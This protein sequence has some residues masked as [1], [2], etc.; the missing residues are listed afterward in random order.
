MSA[1]H[2]NKLESW[3]YGLPSLC[4]EVL[5][6]PFEW[7]NDNLKQVA[8]DPD[9]IMAAIPQYQQVAASVGA[10]GTALGA[11]RQTLSASWAGEAYEAFSARVDDIDQQIAG[12]VA[13]L[14]QMPELLKVSAD[15]CIEGANLIVDIVTSLIMFALST[16]AVNVALAIVTVGTS[17]A[18]GVAAVV[19]RAAT[20]TAKVLRVVEKVAAVLEKVAAAFTKIEEALR[21]ILVFLKKV[22]DMLVQMKAA[23]KGLKGKEFLAAQAKFQAANFGVSTAI[24]VGTG[25]TVAPPG[26]VGLLKDAGQDYV[27]GLTDGNRAN[28]L[29]D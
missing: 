19:A 26:G 9:K 28:Q 10:V 14:G 7:M 27:E 4:Q 29:A 6:E 25:G 16:I 1:E 15:A 11:D 5:Q 3:F 12:I 21:K 23:T 24:K 13:N 8:G 20:E 2:A 17:L 18:A 22:K